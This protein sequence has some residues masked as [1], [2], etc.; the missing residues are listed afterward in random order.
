MGAL[1]VYGDITD[2]SE[3]VGEVLGDWFDPEHNWPTL[4]QRGLHPA[5]DVEAVSMMFMELENGILATYQLCHF[6]PD[7]WRNYTVIGTEGPLEKVGDEVGAT[8][9]VWSRRSRYRADAD[10]SIEVIATESNHGGAD[11]LLMAEFLRFARG[12]SPTLASPIDTREAVAAG[13]P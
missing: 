4:S 1:Q 13:G 9:K 11:E 10:Q 3:R 12:G 6:A 7:Y 8:A 2:R 5:I